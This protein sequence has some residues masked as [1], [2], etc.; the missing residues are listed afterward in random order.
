MNV[1]AHI[2]EVSTYYKQINDT[3]VL[4]SF[5]NDAEI[6]TKKGLNAIHTLTEIEQW[7][8]SN[9]CDS[10]DARLDSIAY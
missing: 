4:Y 6:V 5:L 7:S 8:T 3:T 10:D 1:M 9:S 2:N